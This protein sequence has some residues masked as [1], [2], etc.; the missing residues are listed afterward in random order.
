M[1]I[2]RQNLKY[3]APDVDAVNIC[4]LYSELKLLKVTTPNCIKV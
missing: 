1:Y 3:A 4:I 2:S